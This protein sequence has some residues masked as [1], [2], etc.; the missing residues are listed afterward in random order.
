LRRLAARF[1]D[2]VPFDAGCVRYHDG[3]G[4]GPNVPPG[5][6]SRD[7]LRRH[8]RG[9]EGCEIDARRHHDDA[10][11]RAPRQRAYDRLGDLV[12]D[13]DHPLARAITPL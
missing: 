13:G 7:P 2:V 1:H 12:A 3:A 9:V 5:S 6:H 8:Q 10:A 11:R 4:L